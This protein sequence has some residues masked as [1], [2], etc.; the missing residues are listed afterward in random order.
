MTQLESLSLHFLSFPPHRNHLSLPPP[1]DDR[2]VL[3]ALTCFKYRGISKYLDGLV[4][5]IDAPSLR[6]ID[7]TFFNQPTLDVSQ[8]CL[9]INRIEMQS[10]PLCADIIFS[11]GV[12][13]TFTR[14]ALNTR[15]GLQ[16][17]CGQSDWQLSFISQICDHLSSFLFSVEDLD[18]KTIGLSSMSGNVDDEQWLGLIRAFDG[19]KNLRV[20]GELATDILRALRPADEG[21]KIVLP[22]LRNLHIQPVFMHEP[23]TGSVASFVTQRQLSSRPVQIHYVHSGDINAPQTRTLSGHLRRPVFSDLMHLMTE[24]SFDVDV[25]KRLKQSFIVVLLRLEEEFGCRAT[26][27][28]QNIV[29]V[30]NSTMRD[31]EEAW[32]VWRHDHVRAALRS[33]FA[34]IRARICAGR[35]Q[36]R[37]PAAFAEHQSPDPLSG[38]A[39][40]PSD[41]PGGGE[42]RPGPVTQADE[43]STYYDAH[44]NL[45][46]HTSLAQPSDAQYSQFT[47]T[48]TNAVF[49]QLSR[50]ASVGAWDYPPPPCPPP[51]IYQLLQQQQQQPT[52]NVDAGPPSLSPAVEAAASV[53]MRF[54]EAVNR[55]VNIYL[56]LNAIDFRKMLFIPLE[57]LLP[58]GGNFYLVVGSKTRFTR[59]AFVFVWV[60]DDSLETNER[61]LC[62]HRK[63]SRWS[64]MGKKC[65]V[66]PIA[67]TID[68]I[69]P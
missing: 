51:Q 52:P 2:V 23:L 46:E 57:S 16:I 66:G 48:S 21:H 63:G 59:G 43:V 15:L 40:T 24:H 68:E 14:P 13:V 44:G 62:K 1:P 34:S 18:I 26:E 12:F 54:L 9:F 42:A 60:A 3:P 28:I 64:K 61:S 31:I 39:G 22:A 5:R 6:E 38:Y 41:Q 53:A 58:D 19:T 32:R 55:A 35:Y 36:G 25:L 33:G 49:E 11:G 7:I 4:A 69:T 8:L 47:H 10:S 37:S 67:T 27:P 50:S 17:S 20:I 45:G 65:P 30:L 29:R 56:E